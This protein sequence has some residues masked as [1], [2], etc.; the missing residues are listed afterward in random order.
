MT[1]DGQ[2]KENFGIESEIDEHLKNLEEEKVS[3]SESEE[4]KVFVNQRAAITS[5][6]DTRIDQAS[7]LSQKEKQQRIKEIDR[8][9]KKCLTE[10]KALMT[11]G[12]F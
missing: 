8:E 2:D 3:D 9:M 1:V 11:R 7:S 10:L 5:N 6:Y 12:G 4:N